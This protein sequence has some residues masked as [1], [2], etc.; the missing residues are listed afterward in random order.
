MISHRYTL[1]YVIR[2]VDRWNHQKKKIVRTKHL[3]NKHIK[4]CCRCF[5]TVHMMLIIKPFVISPFHIRRS[6]TT[7]IAIHNSSIVKYARNWGNDM[8][9]KPFE[10][11]LPK[12]QPNN[13]NKTKNARTFLLFCLHHLLI[14]MQWPGMPELWNPVFVGGFTQLRSETYCKSWRKGILH[15]LKFV[16][17]LTHNGNRLIN[18]FYPFYDWMNDVMLDNTDIT[19]MYIIHSE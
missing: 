7:T 17:I 18:G 9:T 12:I 14:V 2:S 13:E 11:L 1:T 19:R 4:T 8:Q 5:I 3:N 6:N 15:K 10:Y 16:Y